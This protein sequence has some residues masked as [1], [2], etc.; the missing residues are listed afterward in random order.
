MRKIKMLLM[1]IVSIGFFMF[2][3]TVFAAEKQNVCSSSESKELRELAS[4][5]KVTYT[6]YSEVVEIPDDPENEASSFTATYVDVKIYNLHTK[7]YV[8]VKNNVGFSRLVSSDDRSKDGSVVLRQELVDSKVN[9]T[10]VV[11]SSYY[12]CELKTLRTIKMTV[13][14]Y[15]VYS[16]LE[17]CAD[18][19]EFYL[20]KQFV[21]SQVDGATFYDKVNAYKAKKAEQIEL[22]EENGV[23]GKTLKNFSKYK[24]LIVGVIVAL[25]VAL[26]VVVIKRKENV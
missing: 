22:E 7:L 6:P 24:Y 25:G 1:L 3:D 10:F 23:I 19:P 18:I 11:K 26:T 13:P 21:T 8:E 12:G 17:A 15:N 4:R 5:I 20:C 14:L 2:T 16:E 9:Y